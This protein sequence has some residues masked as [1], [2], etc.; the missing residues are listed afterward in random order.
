MCSG[1]IM[2]NFRE[3]PLRAMTSPEWSVFAAPVRQTLDGHRCP[4]NGRFASGSTIG[5]NGS[6][7]LDNRFDR[8]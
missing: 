1:S 3:D 2:R 5:E 6:F 4:V 7:I 8:E